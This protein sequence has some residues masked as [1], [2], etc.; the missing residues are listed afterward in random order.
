MNIWLDDDCVK[1]HNLT[2]EHR[3]STKML[4]RDA[5]RG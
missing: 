5:G 4:W 3:S 1:S 2:H